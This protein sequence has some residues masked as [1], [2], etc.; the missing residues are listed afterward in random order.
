MKTNL[1]GIGCDAVN[2]LPSKV[3]PLGDPIQVQP[4]NKHNVIN[5]MGQ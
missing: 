3:A 4:T 2:N 5:N 1:D